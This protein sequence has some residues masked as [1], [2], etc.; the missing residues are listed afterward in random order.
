MI[1]VLLVLQPVRHL[2]PHVQ[3]CQDAVY[4]Y[5]Q[6]IS[7]AQD[8]TAIIQSSEI[9]VALPEHLQNTARISP[10]TLSPKLKLSKMILL[11][12]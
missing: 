1:L 7:V 11:I 4:H 3:P 9:P 6:P 12:L 5:L 2:H 8:A 10:K